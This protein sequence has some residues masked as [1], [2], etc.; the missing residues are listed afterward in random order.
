MSE[1][2]YPE[3]IYGCWCGYT[4]TTPGRCRSHPMPCRAMGPAMKPYRLDDRPL[5]LGEAVTAARGG[6]ARVM[7]QG[8]A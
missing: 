4:S 3:T 5:N 1:N 2:T 7:V 6:P 8:F